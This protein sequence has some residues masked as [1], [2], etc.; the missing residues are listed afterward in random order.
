M[1][2]LNRK[3]LISILFGIIAVIII[4]V[5]CFGFIHKISAGID[6]TEWGLGNY[7]DGKQPVGNAD[8]ET[9]SKYDAYYVGNENEK[10]IYLTFDAGYE[11]GYTEKILDTLKEQKVPATFFLV[12][13]YL[14]K[15]PELVKR[16]IKEGHIVANHTYSHKDLR[17]VS[18]EEFKKQVNDFADL[19][20][21]T[22][23]Q[24]IKKYLRPPEGTF[25]EHSLAMAKSMGYKTIFWSLA[26]N[27]WNNNQ[28]KSYSEV[29][30]KVLPK[31]H[32]G[33]I[34]L[35]HSTSKTNGEVLGDLL[36]KIKE[37]GYTFK[38]LDELAK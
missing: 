3:K 4:A 10:N 8:K 16:M 1:I 28:Q 32:N 9:L 23:G 14:E 29:F 13:N 21:K 6:K 2:D 22:T 18:D 26:Y 20:K 30:D 38:S 12:G 24:E 19:Y 34:L 37:E 31:L 33:C 35:L 27:D 15:N 36:S 5:I 7:G 25:N 17:Y 11:N